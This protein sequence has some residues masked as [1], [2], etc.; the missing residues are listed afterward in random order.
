ME[1]VMV[2][3]T[4]INVYQQVLDRGLFSSSDE[5]SFSYRGCDI[6]NNGLGNDVY[7]IK[8]FISL[9]DAKHSKGDD[10]SYS[11]QICN[12]CLYKTHYGE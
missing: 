9:Y 3:Q 12:E 1:V 4:S 6:C 10:D 5:A 11:F 8:G 2:D 7:D